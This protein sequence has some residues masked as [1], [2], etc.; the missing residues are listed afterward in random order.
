MPRQPIYKELTVQAAQIIVDGVGAP[1]AL[2]PVEDSAEV[3]RILTSGPTTMTTNLAIC[4]TGTP[5]K[6]MEYNFRYE[7]NLDF[8]GNNFTVFGAVIP[9]ILQNKQWNLTATYDGAAWVVRV[10]PDFEQNLIVSSDNIEDA[11]ITDAKVSSLSGSKIAAGTIDDSKF[12]SS[13]GSLKKVSGTLGPVFVVNLN[14]VPV[15]VIPA[16]AG[17]SLVIVKA[18]VTIYGG[19]VA[20]TVNTNLQFR[21]VGASAAQVE[22]DCLGTLASISQSLVEATPPAGAT[23]V[24]QGVGIEGFIETADPAAGDRIVDYEIFYLEI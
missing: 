17:K 3:Y 21:C 4:A 24:I 12:D 10:L 18:T 5:T 16:V 19:G 1:S 22:L 8:N 6:M 7:G 15:T 14:T 20:Y 9:S 11:A 23:Q 2:L 13:L